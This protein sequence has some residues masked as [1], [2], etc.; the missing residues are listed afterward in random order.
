MKRDVHRSG[1][2][3]ALL[4][5][6]GQYHVTH[7]VEWCY[8]RADADGKAPLPRRG[9]GVTAQREPVD[10]A[11]STAFLNFSRHFYDFFTPAR[12]TFKRRSIVIVMMKVEALVHPFLLDDVKAALESLGCDDI[13]VT[14]V[15]LTG[16]RNTIKTRYRGCEYQADVP[17]MKMEILVSSNCVDDVVDLIARIASPNKRDEDRRDDGRILVFEV[18]D[19]IRIRAG[20]RL[21]FSLV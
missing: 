3:N 20:Q 11:C 4:S 6:R 12:L 17:R 14:E 21:E 9:L 16:S 10:L 13:V 1:R 2:A 18:A 15:F 19:V 8:L 7:S 5:R